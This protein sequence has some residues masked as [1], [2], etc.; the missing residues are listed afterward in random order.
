MG[1]EILEL[2]NTLIK[3]F[4]IN[5]NQIIT[6]SDNEMGDILSE[7]YIVVYE[8]YDRIVENERVFINEMKKK[9]LRNNKYGRR[10]E[11]IERW[12]YF[13]ELESSIPERMS[14]TFKLDED[15]IVGLEAI[16]GVTTKEEY[17]FLICYY[18]NGSD[19]TSTI[20]GISNTTC[21]QR[22]CRLKKRIL[23][24]LSK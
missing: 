22:V 7:A 18:E 12:Q 6:N 13:N 8:N 16:K 21:R 11:S 3:R 2:T 19:K 23:E 24:V 20:Y 5:I 15:L 10:I 4:I 14:Y 9:C 17:D 1:E